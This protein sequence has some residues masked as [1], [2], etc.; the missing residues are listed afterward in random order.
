MTASEAL[1]ARETLGLTQQDL[2]AETGLT[3]EIVADWESGR[4]KVPRHVAADLTWRVAQAEVIAGL[5]ASGLPECA[6]FNR[7]DAE[8]M[9]EKTSA[10]TAHLDRLIAHVKDCDACIARDA[11]VRVRFSPMPRPPRH[12]WMAIVIPIAERIDRLPAWAKPA[13]TGAI[14]FMAYSL[15][16]VV[17]MLPA[18]IQDPVRNIPLALMG[19]LASGSIGAALG[20]L[21]GRVKAL[22]AM[23]AARRTA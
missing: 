11:Y 20:F 9:P 15:I 3:P 4:L 12:G 5:A 7:F 18:I 6:W 19:T 13:A 23:W 22:S 1:A 16:K 17:F 10:R 14:F 2:A 8:P 21:Y